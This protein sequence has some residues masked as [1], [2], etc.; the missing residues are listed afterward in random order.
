MR[1]TVKEKLGA[2]MN[3]WV[4]PAK[5]LTIGAKHVLN[6]L[7]MIMMLLGFWDEVVSLS[8]EIWKESMSKRKSCVVMRFGL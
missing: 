3:V 2:A 8:M 6:A 1:S 5:G 4:S 7:M